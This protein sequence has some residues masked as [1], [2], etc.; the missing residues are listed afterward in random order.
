MARKS[1]RRRNRYVHSS[2]SPFDC[3]C[4]AS[5]HSTA[6][7]WVGRRSYGARSGCLRFVSR[8]MGT[9][10]GVYRCRHPAHPTSGSQLSIFTLRRRQYVHIQSP[11][12]APRGVA[13][14]GCGRF[15]NCR[16]AHAIRHT[17][18]MVVA[19]CSV[20]PLRFPNVPRECGDL[21]NLAGTSICAISLAMAF[22]NVCSSYAVSFVC[23]HSVQAK[24]DSIACAG[25]GACRG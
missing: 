18:G 20:H 14:P 3:F 4:L 15:R 8:G 22:P 13:D 1:A 11:F 10:M 23:G 17:G 25:I 2:S 6:A 5:I 12:L 7:L 9:K 19:H 21:A 24:A 16:T